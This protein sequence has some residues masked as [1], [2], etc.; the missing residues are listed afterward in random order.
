MTNITVL[1]QAKI[2]PSKV[3]CSQTASKLLCFAAFF[4]QML[5]STAKPVESHLNYW[6]CTVVNK[7]QKMQPISIT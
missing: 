5:P 2:M 4:V 1:L 6:C 7:K 3:S